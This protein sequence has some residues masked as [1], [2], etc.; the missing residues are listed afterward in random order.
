MRFYLSRASRV[1]RSGDSGHLLR[2]LPL[3][4]FFGIRPPR[5]ILRR[6]LMDQS[7]GEDLLADVQSAIASLAG[8]TLAERLRE[9]LQVDRTSALTQRKVRLVSLIARNDRLLRGHN[10]GLRRG[11]TTDMAVVEVDGLIS[12]CNAQPS[13]RLLRS[14]NSDCGTSDRRIK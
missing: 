5:M 2:R 10:A 9:A 8:E 14:A 4:L 6:L 12:F 7:S 11:S 13:S 3:R 1:S